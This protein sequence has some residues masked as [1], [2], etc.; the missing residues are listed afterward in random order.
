MRRKLKGTGSFRPI[1]LLIVWGL[2]ALL[3][4]AN[5]I[6]ETKRAKDNLLQMLSDEGSVLLTGMEKTAQSV[7]SSLTAIESFPDLSAFASSIDF[8]SMEESVVEIIFDLAFQ[9]DQ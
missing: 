6:Y 3:L 4:A 2:L 9:I 1:H 5:G 7:F 8:L